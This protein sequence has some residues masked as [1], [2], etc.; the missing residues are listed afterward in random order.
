MI[1]KCYQSL[2]LWKLNIAVKF[3]LMDWLAM[4]DNYLCL[5]SAWYWKRVLSLTLYAFHS[6]DFF[7][8]GQDIF[9]AVIPRST[10]TPC[11]PMFMAAGL[12]ALN[13]WNSLSHAQSEQ[14][15]YLRE[16]LDLKIDAGF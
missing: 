3:S 16:R 13:S 10:F 1:N 11:K 14:F 8:L 2:L 5:A 12:V 7:V 15:N 6:D 9:E 4:C